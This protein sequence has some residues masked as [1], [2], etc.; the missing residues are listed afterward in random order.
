[1]GQ[2]LCTCIC[3]LASLGTLTV[4]VIFALHLGSGTL[5]K[6]RCIVPLQLGEKARVEQNA[7]LPGVAPVLPSPVCIHAKTSV[8]LN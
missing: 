3:G 8:R 1:M 5:T 6:H 4:T 2:A 7:S